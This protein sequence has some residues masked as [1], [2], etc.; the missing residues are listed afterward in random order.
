MRSPGGEMSD[1]DVPTARRRDAQ[2]GARSG[3]VVQRPGGS[4]PTDTGQEDP[5]Q[6]AV[7]HLRLTWWVVGRILCIVLL[8]L[9]AWI[10]WT[11][12]HSYTAAPLLVP[13]AVLLLS[14][15]VRLTGLIK[16]AR[17]DDHAPVLL[18]SS[19]RMV[20]AANV[21]DGQSVEWRVLR[22]QPRVVGTA[23]IRGPVAP[24]RWVVVRLPN[25][26][27]I[28]PRSRIQPVV[29]TGTLQL[30]AAILCDEG[31]LA[32]VHQ[33][34]AGYVQTIRLVADLPL[35]VRRPPGPSKR[36]WLVGA[37]RPVVQAL[38]VIQLRRRLAV[39]A[40]ALVHRAM[41]TSGTDGGR[42]R[43]RLLEASKECRALAGS[44]PRRRWFAAVAAIAATGLTIFSPFAS[45]PHIPGHV[46]TKHA[47][48]V[49]LASLAFGVVPMLMFF[50]AVSCKRALLSPATA[51]PKWAA[52]HEAPWL[53][54]DWDVYQLEKD[55]F[56]SAVAAEPREWESWRW[57]PWLVGAVYG[58]A[59]GIPLI[60]SD[61]PAALIVIA[62]AIALYALTR[63]RWMRAARKRLQA[64]SRT[65][66]P[67]PDPSAQ[68]V[69]SQQSLRPTWADEDAPSAI[70]KQ[71]TAT[72]RQPNAFPPT[73]PDNS[74][75]PGPEGHD[76][77][78]EP[79]ELLA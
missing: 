62:A 68:P 7:D 17:G 27:L 37:P 46:I 8:A 23:R 72:D 39:L 64:Q 13:A 50:H 15:A 4:G 40:S 5:R 33:L 35:V 31:P 43:S 70:Q 11:A 51:M 49:I 36:W 56:A 48:Q 52:V 21:V 30:P 60:Y 28:W 65:G 3:Y 45:L 41:E 9:P 44:L 73:L 42:A 14:G 19:G 12:D 25:G 18:R 63:W 61:G 55:A 71:R 78:N 2:P 1:R 34:L 74:P 24:G 6:H 53:R 58:T 67:L 77:L 59:F 69:Q 22:W 76:G 66:V 29:G 10:T 20:L 16:A 32:G 26:R 75:G 54:A 57:I 79:R 38:I 47:L